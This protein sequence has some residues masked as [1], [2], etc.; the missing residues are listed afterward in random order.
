MVVKPLSLRTIH[1]F[2]VPFLAF[3]L[4]LTATTGILF[5]IA[6]LN[7]RGDDFLWLLDLHQG[8]FGQINLTMLYPF[9]N[10]LGILTLL[11]TGLLMW[12]KLPV[13][14]GYLD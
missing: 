12:L 4:L 6:V 5:Q 9:L 7:D 8:H 13:N 2:L 3:P 14:T 11:V 10:G 1:K